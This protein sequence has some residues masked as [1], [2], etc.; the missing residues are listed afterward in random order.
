MLILWCSS[1][2]EHLSVKQGVDS[3]NLST[4]AKWESSSI[5]RALRLGRR[6][7]RFKSCL[8]HQEWL[9]MVTQADCKSVPE[10]VWWFNSTLLHQY[11][12]VA[13]WDRVWHCD[14]QD[15]GST[16]LQPS[17]KIWGCS[18]IG[19]APVLQAGSYGFKSHRLHHGALV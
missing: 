1:M 10:R 16:P 6:S 8:S 18:S 5:G 14:C 7:C 12:L 9:R 17:K 11:G 3:S 2:V 13:Q 4:T 15:S 19:R